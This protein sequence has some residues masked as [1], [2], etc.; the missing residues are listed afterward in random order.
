MRPLLNR[1]LSLALTVAAPFAL[2]AAPAAALAMLVPIN[3]AER[4]DLRGGAASVVVGNT[5]IASVTVVDTHTIYIMGRSAGSTNVI[6]LDKAGRLLFT[7]DITVAGTGS[8]V[9]LYRGA[10]RTQV[11]CTYSCVELADSDQQSTASIKDPA[12]MSSAMRA[13]AAIAGGMP[14]PTGP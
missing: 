1:P 10:K 11:N 8:N 14:P 12:D 9:N 13:V 3:H 7:R 6:V 2:A 4:I 5:S